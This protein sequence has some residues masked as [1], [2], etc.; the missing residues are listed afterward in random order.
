MADGLIARTEMRDVRSHSGREYRI[1]VSKPSGQPGP[2]GYPVLYLLDGNA[3]F[4]SAAVGVALQSR[5]P[6]VTGVAPAIVVG[7]GYPIDDYLDSERRTYDYTPAVVPEV[8]PPRPDGSMWPQTGGAE[9]FLDFLEHEL[10]P[11]IAREFA[12]DPARQGIF[13]HS[14][15]GL[16]VLYA[17][18]TRPGTFRSYVAASPSIWFGDCFVL[19]ARD[20]FMA[21][22]PPVRPLDLLI[23]VGDRE[24]RARDPEGQSP[25]GAA[26]SDWVKRNRMVENATEL[27]RSLSAKPSVQVTFKRFEDENH[28]SVLLPA[29][30]RALRFALRPGQP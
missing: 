24:D 25:A 20:A 27:A 22:P 28:S 8:L 4:P 6:D 23:T 29:I 10:K 7:V 1:F 18:F 11:A 9:G 5:R 3:T 30:G 16:F 14:F 15:G 21:G 12:V 17:L 2:S 26:K 19:S 13:G